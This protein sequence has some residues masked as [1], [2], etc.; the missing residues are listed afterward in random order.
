LS[1]KQR[2]TYYLGRRLNS[3]D[4]A[5]NLHVVVI[6][7]INAGTA[8]VVYGLAVN[9]VIGVGTFLAQLFLRDPLMKAFTFELQVTGPWK[10]PVVNKI[11]RHPPRDTTGRVTAD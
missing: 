9:P 1:L 7:E 5:Q 10:E 6:P 8:S 3:Y 4:E 2:T 11:L